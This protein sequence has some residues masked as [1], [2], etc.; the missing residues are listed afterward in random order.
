LLN[1]MSLVRKV[2]IYVIAAILIC[3]IP[4][5]IF[6]A[7]LERLL[8]IEERKTNTSAIGTTV[9]AALDPEEFKAIMESRETNEYYYWFSEFLDSVLANNNLAYLLVVCA[10]YDTHFTYFAEGYPAQPR[11]DEPRLVLGDRESIEYYADEMFQSIATGEPTTTGVVEWEDFGVLI[12]GAAPVKDKYGEV[13]AVVVV[14][15]HVEDA[16]LASRIFTFSMI[17]ITVVIIAILSIVSIKISKNTFIHLRHMA[18]AMTLIREEGTLTLSN[19]QEKSMSICSGWGS[20]IGDCAKAVEQMLEHFNNLAIAA[21]IQA[22]MLPNV[23]PAFPDRHEFDI[24]AQMTPAK[25]VGGDFYDFFMI[26]K[27][28]L[29]IVIADVSGKGIPAALFMANS[30]TQLKNATLH[31]YPLNEVFEM[32]NNT[33]CE[34]N[35]ECMFVTVFMGILDIPTRHLTYISA[36]HDTPLLKRNGSYEWLPLV[37]GKML[38]FMEGEKYVENEIILNEEDVL[39]LYTDGV[40]EAEN[41]EETI[42]TEERLISDINQ[43]KESSPKEILAYIQNSI[44]KFTGGAEQSDDITM[45]AIKIQKGKETKKKTILLVDDDAQN[46]QT[47]DYILHDEYDTISVTN[48]SEAIQLANEHIPDLI[49]LDIVMPEMDGFQVLKALKDND[50]TRHIPIIFVTGLGEVEDETKGLSLGASDY[51]AK[52][53]DNEIVKF[54]VRNQINISEQ[55]N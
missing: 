41:H 19:E 40:T 26:N 55:N 18:N 46:L 2:T 15:Y 29:A 33:L 37:P 47:L 31:G 50:K 44:E 21:K 9:A 30:K 51:I 22:S 13:V 7:Y 28:K 1:N 12:S 49:L 53:F 43:C 45:L 20:E 52:P 48:G 4:L 5:V 11:Y 10:N 24:Y 39:F 16:L 6:A 27:Y 36:G 38:G 34:N 35:D 14:D 54:R 3:A 23:F 17:G 32:A 25:E 8:I 42:Y